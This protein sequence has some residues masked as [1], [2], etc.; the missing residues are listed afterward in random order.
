MATKTFTWR[1]ERNLTPTI[2]YRT[3][4]TQFGDGYEQVSSDGIN[5]KNESWAVRVTAKTEKEAGEIMDFF[6][7][8]GGVHSFLWK[9][10]LGKTA[11]YRCDNPTPT[12][13]GGGVYVITGTF[14]KSYNNPE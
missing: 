3:T 9:P 13:Q 2:D 4:K 10:P 1:V 8:L 5:T 11:L 6:D 12:P 7:S 14:V